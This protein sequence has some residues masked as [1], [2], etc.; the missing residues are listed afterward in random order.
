LVIAVLRA[1]TN[2]DENDQKKMNRQRK[3][4]CTRT[5][6]ATCNM[7]KKSFQTSCCFS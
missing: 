3:A 7:S 6:A 1:M 2:K 5:K 4:Y